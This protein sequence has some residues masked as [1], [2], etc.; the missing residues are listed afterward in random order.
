M[1]A[2][3]LRQTTDVVN[4][5]IEIEG[6]ALPDTVA[7]A[8]VEI[9]A[10]VNRIP[11]SRLR[12]LDGDV[13]L[14]DFPHSSGELFLPGNEIII[15][16]GYRDEVESVFS[17]VIYKQRIVV[18]NHSTY[19][20][21]E[22]RDPAIKMT[23]NRICRYHEE[24]SDSDIAELLIDEHGLSS[25]IA[26]TEVVHPQ[27]MQFYASDWDFML[28]RLEANGHLCS[29]SAGTIKSFKPALEG[30]PLVDIVFGDTLLELETELDARSQQA[31]IVTSAWDP[32]DQALL[33]VEAVEPGWQSNGDLTSED[34]VAA[35]ERSEE[36]LLHGG[37]LANDALQ[38]WADGA[39]L[40]SR[41]RAIR[42]RAKFRGI[43]SLQ[44]G[45][46]VQL[47]SISERFNGIIL[48][49]SIR[50]EF[51]NNSWFTDI[52]FGLPE[53]T[54][55]ES[56][57]TNHLPAAGLVPAISGLQ[58]GVVTQLA[59]DPAGENRVRVKIPVAGMD[60]QGIWARVA[61]LDAGPDRG[62]FFRPEVDDEVALGFLHGDPAQPILL[63]MLHSSANAP[64][65]EPSE[66]NFE[67]AYVS[68][69]GLKFH[70]ND[71]D[72]V[73]TLETP[74]GNKATLSDADEGI[75]LEDQHGNMVILNADGITLTSSADL[76]LDAQGDINLN[77]A[78]IALAA[79]TEFKAEG[80][81]AAAV[82]SSGT[83]EISGALVQIN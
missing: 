10:K 63:G 34:L 28:N 72:K 16:A 80:S 48:V 68:R 59:D 39:L 58:L 45:D 42:G 33:E 17:G 62:T 46:V 20:E 21:V 76:N 38:S 79:S 36:V 14:Q 49:T 51:S 18:R 13:A 24:M 25:E 71:E 29:V 2:S 70:F 81:S 73:I 31:T 57:S 61:T 50:H 4:L 11:F 53:K 41:M 8:S 67:K 82:T 9:I 23:L 55:A 43:P 40:R 1:T 66:D 19:L 78:N 54:H 22:C 5:T 77:G 26:P 35:T 52:E 44:L 69:E 27:L 60:E 75:S 7:V 47:S 74:G 3:P 83:L 32:S 6:N 65:I 37:S 15:N 30:D 56:Y 64:P 12:I